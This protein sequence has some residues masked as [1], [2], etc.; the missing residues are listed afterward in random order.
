MSK[1]TNYDSTWSS[2]HGMLYSCT[3]MATVD[4]KRLIINVKMAAHLY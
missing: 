4:V 1:F 2:R 3:H